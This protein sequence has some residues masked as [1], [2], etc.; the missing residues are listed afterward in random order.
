LHPFCQAF[1]SN[2]RFEL[3]NIDIYLISLTLHFFKEELLLLIKAGIAGAES[4]RTS[5]RVRANMS[6]AVEI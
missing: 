1:I 3:F 4:K 5:E 2:I 6:R